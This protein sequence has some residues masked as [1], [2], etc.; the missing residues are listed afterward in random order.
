MC[1]KLQMRWSPMGAQFLLHVR[2]A[3]LN[4]RL[5]NYV[6]GKGLDW[7]GGE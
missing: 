2:T 4:G 1:K 5:P 3:I 7:Y 6:F